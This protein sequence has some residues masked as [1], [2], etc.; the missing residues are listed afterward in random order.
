M[1]KGKMLSNTK[2]V[3]PKLRNDDA[4]INFRMDDIY[5]ER[6]SLMILHLKDGFLY[7]PLLIMMDWRWWFMGIY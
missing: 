2:L 1:C 3:F 7:C 4:T 6:R 5:D